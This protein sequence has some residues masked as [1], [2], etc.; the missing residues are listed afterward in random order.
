MKY[1]KNKYFVA[2]FMFICTFALIPF[3]IS[4]SVDDIQMLDA[5]YLDSLPESVRKDI[6]NEIKK[7]KES[8]DISFKKRPSSELQK[9]EIVKEWE[10]FQRQR[11]KELYKSERYGINLFR[12]M[13][14]SFMPINEPNFGNNY[15][16]DY[17]DEITI[18]L[19]GNNNDSFE[20][21]IQRDGSI[22]IPE[23]GPIILAGYNYQQG[24]E[25]IKSKIQSSY[26]GTEVDVKLSKI[27]DVKVLITGNVEFPGIYTLSGNSNVLQALN[28]AGGVDEA[29]TLRNIEIKRN[30]DIV[31]KVDIYQAL[32][33]GDL[34]QI[35]Q[36]QSGDAIYVRPANKLVRAGSGFINEALYELKDDENLE[37]L[38]AFSGGIKK[39]ESNKTFSLVSINGTVNENI[40]F[41]IK[42]NL[43]SLNHLDSV[44]FPISN[45][46]TVRITGE[47]LRPGKYTIKSGDN[48]NDLIIRA[49]GYSS[50]A[51][52]LAGILKRE[53]V[54]ELES[55]YSEKIYRNIISYLAQ[56]PDQLKTNTQLGL[57]LEEFKNV[58]PSGR[59]VTEFDLLKVK[60]DP[61]KNIFLEDG[62]EIH[63]PKLQNV[64]YVYGDVG[65]PKALSF[66][67][68][69][70]V[71][72]YL[73]KAGGLNKTANKKHILVISPNG[74]SKVVNMSKFSSILK[75]DIDIY[76]GTL[77]YIPPEIGLVQGIE[78]YSI[79][80]PI[81][82]SLALSLAS[83]N[84]IN[85]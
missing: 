53:Q 8:D 65:D 47:V 84:A 45:L 80:A 7:S 16:L 56:N 28:I 41:N 32:I 34:S 43:I 13:Q 5:D 54:K 68:F 30:G 22:S 10:R 35:T 74:E 14:S 15:I 42:D 85:D 2:L 73:S 60:K 23:I 29:G 83:L 58:Q 4:Q 50:K 33:F 6:E 64:V 21:E 48:L 44:Y 12:T 79:V 25:S 76:P 77:I 20:L 75:N 67:D 57:I 70:N 61:S 71:S 38:I 51:Y 82:S 52:S 19:F 31:K 26:I 24:V 18:N 9:Y 81:F 66:K 36:L 39:E 40:N 27:R 59:I 69:D 11:N 3:S 1:Y 72:D 37:H 17:G 63:I 46:G 78:F 55:K 62:D 49:G